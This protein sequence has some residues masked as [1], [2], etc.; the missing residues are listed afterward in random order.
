MESHLMITLRTRFRKID[1]KDI[2]NENFMQK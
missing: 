2:L 1:D